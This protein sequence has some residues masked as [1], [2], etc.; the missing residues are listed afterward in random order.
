MYLIQSGGSP[1]RRRARPGRGAAGPS[2][3]GK[4]TGI[5]LPQPPAPTWPLATA[6]DPRGP[7]QEGTTGRGRGVAYDLGGLDDHILIVSGG[8]VNGFGVAIGRV[9][10]ELCSVSEVEKE[11]AFLHEQPASECILQLLVAHRLHLLPAQC[12]IRPHNMPRNRK[13]I[14]GLKNP[15]DCL[16]RDVL[17]GEDSLSFHLTIPHLKLVNKRHQLF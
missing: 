15:K 5:S 7:C 16:G 11:L 17:E 10:G 9:I 1:P 13:W 14:L 2:T 4:G 6:R 12:H 3:P 8:R